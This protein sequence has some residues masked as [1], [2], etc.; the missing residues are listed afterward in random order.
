MEPLLFKF[1]KKIKIEPE[2]SLDNTGVETRNLPNGINMEKT[3]TNILSEILNCEFSTLQ[4]RCEVTVEEHPRPLCCEVKQN[5]EVRLL[6][7]KP[8]FSSTPCGL[9][10]IDGQQLKDGDRVLLCNESNNDNNGVWDVSSGEWRKSPDIGDAKICII[11]GQF[12]EN[13]KW[14]RTENGEF[15]IE[16]DF[17]WKHKKEEWKQKGRGR[18]E[19][20]PG[21]KMDTEYLRKSPETN[22]ENFPG[23]S[24]VQKQRL[25]KQMEEVRIYR[26]KKWHKN[27]Q[28][29]KNPKEPI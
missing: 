15:H 6:S 27:L 26:K 22:V 24:Q 4:K 10:I 12:Y 14:I 3:K 18:K 9:I 2:I 8:C 1:T 16:L 13:T 7:S 21:H 11:D 20:S 23:L 5:Y 28:R 29:V 19:D 25:K 17:N